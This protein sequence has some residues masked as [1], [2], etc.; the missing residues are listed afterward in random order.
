M[1]KEQQLSEDDLNK[2]KDII[3]KNKAKW[4]ALFTCYR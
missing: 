4:P 2:I 3:N 1:V